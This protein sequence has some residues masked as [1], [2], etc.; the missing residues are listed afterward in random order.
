MS[1]SCKRKGILTILMTLVVLITIAIPVLGESGPSTYRY[2]E[3]RTGNT[4]LVSNIVSP[5]VRWT[6]DTGSTSGSPPMAGDINND[7]DMEIVFGS[8]NGDVYAIDGD[9]NE[10]WTFQGEGPIYA[11][12]AIGDVNGD[13]INDVVIGGYYMYGGDPNLYALN[14]EDGD[15]LWTFT[16]IDKGAVYEKG[17]EC[18]PTLYDINEDGKL[19]VL[20]GSIN[21]NF[22]ALDGEDGTIIWESEFEHFIR[23][24]SPVGDIDQDGTDE[25]LVVDNHAITRLF[26]VDGDLD[27]EINVGYGVAATPIFADVDGDGFDEIIM[28]SF[29]W[30]AMGILG[31]AM[32]YEND[33]TLLWSNEEHV[34]FFSSPTLYDVDGDG[35]LDIINVDSNDQILIAYKGTDG[36]VLYTAEPFEPNFMAPGLITADIDG[37][38]ETEVLV[39]GNPNLFS[40]NAADG[41]VEWVYDSEGKWVGGPLVVDLDGDGNAEIVIR[42]GGKLIVIH[43]DFDPFDLLD[44]IIAYILG[45]PDECFKNN[46][47]NRKNTL[48]NKLEEIRKMMIDE[49]YEAAISKWTNDIRPKMDGEGKN[50]WIICG[51]AQEDLTD[52]IDELIEYLQSLL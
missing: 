47:D 26:E 35:L 43:N 12:A 6:F 51:Y 46:A 44:K 3:K 41:S 11:P 21:R 40:I 16:T 17:F 2:D 27:W 18:A 23:A 32:V 52:M 7:G 38:G 8:A 36:S 10:I 49:D 48:V 5:G 30:Q 15:L 9:G 22:Y 42:A 13:G 45:L 20:I 33:G 37:D 34:F 4:N 31:V 1:A 29:G 50:D 39:G 24:T 19:D 28:F 25:I 14:G